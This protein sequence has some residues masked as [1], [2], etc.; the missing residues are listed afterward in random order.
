MNPSKGPGFTFPFDGTRKNIE[1]CD[2]PACDDTVTALSA[3]LDRI[4]LQS[5]TIGDT[6]TNTHEKPIEC[7]PSKDSLG[8]SSWSLLHSMVRLLL[9]N[10]FGIFYHRLYFTLLFKA[11]WYPDK[12][13]LEEETKMKNFMEALSIFYPCSYCARDFQENLA[14]SPARYVFTLHPIMSP[15]RIYSI[16]CYLNHDSE[17]HLERTFPF[18]YVSNTI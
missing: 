13:T 17:R 10:L 3:A 6:N 4:S 15:F 2:R 16:T 7:P 9:C 5:K 12:P 8:R 1:N 11:A 18:G 14:Q